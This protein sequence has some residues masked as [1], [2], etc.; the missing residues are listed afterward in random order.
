MTNE[1]RLAEQVRV[2]RK[3]LIEIERC[4]AWNPADGSLKRC[5]NMARIAREAFDKV[6]VLDR[7]GE[8]CMTPEQK[9][10]IDAM[11][12]YDLCRMWRFAPVGEP[13]LRGDTG[14]Y[15]AK[16]LEELGGFTPEISKRLGW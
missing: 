5:E 15:F 14:D 9:A 12:Q 4:N 11:S 3:A 7:Y 13:L 16:R 1:E 10:E 6:H 8:N 2:M